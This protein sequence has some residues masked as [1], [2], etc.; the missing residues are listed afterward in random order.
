MNT[1][2]YLAPILYP[3]AAAQNDNTDNVHHHILANGA[4]PSLSSLANFP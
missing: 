1:R 4:V 2:H 3:P